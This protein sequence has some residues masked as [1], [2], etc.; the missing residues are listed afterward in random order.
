MRTGWTVRAPFRIQPPA[1]SRGVHG[2]SAVVDPNAYVWSDQGWR[3]VPLSEAIIYELHV[4]TFTPQGTFAGVTERLPYLAD[5]GITVVELMPVADFPGSHNWGYDGVSL[6]APSRAY[7][8]GDDLRHLVNTAHGLGL[9]VLLDVVYNHLGPD[10]AYASAFSPRYLSTR[11][12]SPWGAAVNLDGEGSRQ[13]REFFI[14]NALHRL[15]EYHLDGLRL[16]ATHGLID[17]SPRHV[18]A[19]TPRSVARRAHQTPH[20]RTWLA[21]PPRPCRPDAAGGVRA[22]GCAGSGRWPDPRLCALRCVRHID[23]HCAAVDLLPAVTRSFTIAGRTG[24]GRHAGLATG[25]DR[26]PPLSTPVDR[27]D[28]AVGGRSARRR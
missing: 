7:G 18:V 9:G 19:E 11:H 27:R 17:D 15:H 21:L 12:K 23:R 6:F 14:E 2:P 25:R 20:S 5:L 24:M 26:R 10:G 4:G 22:A 13:V 16:D 1:S 28:H 3:G 8:T